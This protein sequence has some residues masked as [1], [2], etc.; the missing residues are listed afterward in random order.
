MNIFFHH[1]QWMKIR[2]PL[3]AIV[4]LI[5]FFIVLSSCNKYDDSALVE[6]MVA[7]EQRVL[8]LEELCQE[9]NTNVS[10]LKV[11]VTALQ[12]KDYVTGVNP[13]VQGQTVIGYSISF[14]KSPAIT[15]YHGK[16]GE[17]PIIGVTEIDGIMYW[18]ING[19]FVTDNKGNKICA[20]ARDGITP[21]FR[22]VDGKWQLS[23][24]GGKTWKEVGQA[25]GDSP[26]IGVAEFNGIMYWTINGK[27]VTDSKGNKIC[28]IAQD[29]ITPQLRIVDGKWQLSYDGGK[30]WKDVGQ[31][32]GDSPVIGVAEFDGIMYWTINGEFVTDN[33]GNKICATAQ[34][35]ITPQLR[36]VDGK[37]Q[38]SYD[39]GKTW[40]EVGQ[41]TGDSM[42]KVISDSEEKVHIELTNGYVIDIPKFIALKLTLNDSD[43]VGINP[44]GKAT[45]EYKLAGVNSKPTIK[46]ICPN[47][48]HAEVIQVSNSEGRIEFTAPETITSEETIILVSDNEGR[49]VMATVNFTQG[50]INP[51]K[52][53]YQISIDGGTV[54]V[55]VTTNLNYTVQIPTADNSWIKLSSIATRS[56][57]VDYLTF[58]IT[59]NTGVTR[60]SEIKFLDAQ[61]REMNAVAFVQK[62]N[63]P[64]LSVSKESVSYDYNPSSTVI[65]VTSNTGWTVNSSAQWCRVS[66]S[67]GSNN[68]SITISVDENKTNEKRQC[69]VTVSTTKGN[70]TKNITVSQ[71]KPPYYHIISSAEELI[72][73]CN[74]INNGGE[75]Q[76]GR[77]IADITL[78]GSW[79]GIG[80]EAQPFSGIF[81]GN[82]HSISGLTSQSSYS[83]LF[84]VVNNATIHNINVS[85]NLSNA[86]YMGG[87]AGKAVSSTFDNCRSS[88]NISSGSYIGGIVGYTENCTVSNC[89]HTDNTIGNTSSNYAGG[90][91]GNTSQTEIYNCYN[92]GRIYGNDCFG[93]IVGYNGSSS[94][95]TNCY[96]KAAFK[97]MYYISTGGGIVGYNCGRIV[98]CYSSGSMTCK[99][100][101]GDMGMKNCG[102]VVGY[103][104]TNSS[105]YCC[106]FLQQTPINNGLSYVGDLNWG[107]C[108]K[109][110]PFD[111]SG[112]FSSSSLSYSGSTT[113]LRTSLNQWV[114]ANQAGNKYKKWRTDQSWPEFAE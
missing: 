33:K 93:G 23:S 112:L 56:V 64:T 40:K 94:T 36:I 4:P 103:N 45:V 60:T 63:D 25:T 109:C 71:G 62:G 41:A 72:A 8:R 35:G 110:G 106:Y 1:F 78:S 43:E 50:I 114:T 91:V 14:T 57:R 104:H 58:Q 52:N 29:G 21:Q 5:L 9:L 49:M 12:D 7:L 10:S 81:D 99:T 77:L 59:K 74:Y 22:I 80:T 105:C 53:S 113:Y 101:N 20:S 98:N 42:F 68:S 46:T 13:I 2:I 27:F 87:I 108:S 30:T 28:A 69:V 32:T 76:N 86:Q 6:R 11:L 55:P 70:L 24:D 15:I 88:I 66:P 38:L 31:A 97:D 95:I 111:A 107:S 26:V 54:E 18:T 51:A 102:G 39:G 89:A 79:Q 96:N 82:G 47:G 65:S 16:D 19:E 73:F 61:G 90:I 84:G 34:D 92:A 37:W 83:G 100:I 44:G 67:S 17:T 3:M 85:G 48:W 75:D